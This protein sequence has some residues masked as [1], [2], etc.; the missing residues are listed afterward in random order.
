MY[1]KDLS[2]K[3]KSSLKIKKEKGLFLGSK[4]P[5]GYKKSPTDK[6]TLIINEEECKVVKLIFN[7]Y[8]K[9]FNCNKNKKNKNKNNYF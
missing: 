3:I 8:N 7:M 1:S 5:Y 2:K 9:G 6:Y 4:A